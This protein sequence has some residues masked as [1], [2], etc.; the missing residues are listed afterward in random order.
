MIVWVVWFV[1]FLIS[2]ILDQKINPI[3]DADGNII[4]TNIIKAII[5]SLLFLIGISFVVWWFQYFLNNPYASL[6]MIPIWYVLSLW[7]HPIKKR[8]Y[9]VSRWKIIPIW[10]VIWGLLYVVLNGVIHTIPSN[11][12]NI[13]SSWSMVHYDYMLWT[14]NIKK[15]AKNLRWLIDGKFELGFLVDLLDKSW[16]N[17]SSDDMDIV[18]SWSI[19]ADW[20][21]WY[22]DHD[23]YTHCVAIPDM[24]WCW[25][26]LSSYTW[27][28]SI[29]NGTIEPTMV[30]DHSSMVKSELD[31]LALMVPHHQEAV[32]SSAALLKRPSISPR[33]KPILENIISSQNTEI[34]SM[35]WW[36][37]KRYNG[38]VYTW[39]LYI[40]MMRDIS[41][42]SDI[43]TIESVYVQDMIWH[44]QW[45]IQMAEKVLTLSGVHE[46]VKSLAKNIIK[47]QT[48]D[49]SIFESILKSINNA[50]DNNI[51][52]GTNS[53]D[54]DTM[55]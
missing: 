53:T 43:P 45:A 6:M 49:I 46:E 2:Y 8:L 19:K 15:S 17:I 4:N 55:R 11:L 13:S 24:D 5:V 12:Y 40:P 36:L 14:Q 35:L 51:G 3:Y 52:T 25:D 50:H 42:I 33:L 18:W 39:E 48:N 31:F 30:I 41:N 44:H 29:P 1:L 21:D 47:D 27:D 32:D 23:I 28:T 26:F 16:N 22:S 20:M 10:I 9:P 7:I 54:S 37:N 34:R 38:V